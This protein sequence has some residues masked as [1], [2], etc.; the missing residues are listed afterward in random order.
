MKNDIEQ[1]KPQRIPIDEKSMHINEA[2]TDGVLMGSICKK[3]GEHYFGKQTYCFKCASQDFKD[4]ELPKQGILRTYTVIFTPPAGWQGNV[5]YILGSVEL[6]ETPEI[7]SEVIDCPKENI[8]IGMRMQ[9]VFKVGGTD[10]EG[11][12]IVVYKWKP[13]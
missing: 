2:G 10:K 3:C 13:V 5:P 11:N 7:L 9:L 8:K 1:K 6:T 12:E 4:I